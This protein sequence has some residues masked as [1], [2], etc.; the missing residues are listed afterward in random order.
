[1]ANR[2]LTTR[3]PIWVR[4]PGVIALVLVGVLFSTAL[5]GALDVAGRGGDHGPDDQGEMDRDGGGHGSDDETEREDGDHGRGDRDSDGGGHSRGDWGR[6][7]PVAPA[8]RDLP[9]GPAQV[10]TFAMKHNAFEPAETA[11]RRGALARRDFENTGVL[12]RVFA[13][14][15]LPIEDMRGRA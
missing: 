11:G 7:G 9:A 15:D 12:L 4:V 1:M 3:I 6:G 14:D 2:A 8:E 13:F 10:V 5:L